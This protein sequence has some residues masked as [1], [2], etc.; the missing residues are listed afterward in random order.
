MALKPIEIATRH[1]GPIHVL[2][3]DMVMPKMGGRELGTRMAK[4]RP[5]TKTIYM[6]GYAEH[7]SIAPNQ[8]EEPPVLLTKPFT[9]A[10]LARAVTQILQATNT[11]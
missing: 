2:I 7:D 9:R 4:L 6:S 3:T 5:G 1:A 10:T 11:H 8:G